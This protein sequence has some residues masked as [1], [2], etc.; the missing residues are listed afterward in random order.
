MSLVSV[1]SPHGLDA[2]PIS[3]HPKELPHNPF[4]HVLKPHPLCQSH[5]LNPG[6]VDKAYAGHRP[7]LCLGTMAQYSKVYVQKM[8]S[9]A[10]HIPGLSWLREKSVSLRL[11][12]LGSPRADSSGVGMT[13]VC[14]CFPSLQSYTFLISSDYER[15]EWRESIR[16]Q[17]KKCEW[18]CTQ[19]TR[20]S[21][22]R[23][24]P[25]GGWMDG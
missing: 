12:P 20:P 21:V 4:L 25:V 10:V 22:T 13:G 18:P 14:S 16:E 2:D 24:G 8:V 11:C 15:A 1:L 6:I 5:S 3:P 23:A 7:I 19:R 17:Q 9:L